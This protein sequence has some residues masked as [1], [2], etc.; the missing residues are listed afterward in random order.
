MRALRTQDPVAQSCAVS[1]LWR[2]GR[3]ETDEC[4][5]EGARGG[6]MDSVREHAVKGDGVDVHGH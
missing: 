1:G 3:K 2:N 6:G 4:G 5:K